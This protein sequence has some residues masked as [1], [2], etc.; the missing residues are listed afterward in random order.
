[1]RSSEILARTSLMVEGIRP[2]GLHT[3]QKAE[4]TRR[5]GQPIQQM[6]GIPERTHRTGPPIRPMPGRILQRFVR[7]RET[8]V[9]LI[10][11]SLSKAILLV[12]ASL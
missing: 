1:M 4:H 6:A 12:P 9:R 8:F 2:K 5:K 3:R 7:I 10:S 11:Q